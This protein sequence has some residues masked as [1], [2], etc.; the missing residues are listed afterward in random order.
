MTQKRKAL[1]AYGEDLAA[2]YLVGQGLEIWQ[3]NWRC[4]VGEVD[5]VALDQGELVICEVKTRKSTKFGYPVEAITYKKLM[6]LRR[7]AGWWVAECSAELGDGSRFN[8]MRIDVVGIL[9]EPGAR[10]QVTHLKGVG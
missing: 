7:L 1:G 2:D 5:I 3:R 8:S 6:K 10:P 9:L 4:L